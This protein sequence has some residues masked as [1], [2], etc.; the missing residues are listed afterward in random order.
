MAT[1]DILTATKTARERGCTVLASLGAPRAPCALPY[2]TLRRTAK[3]VPDAADRCRTLPTDTRTLLSSPQSADDAAAAVHEASQTSHDTL[4]A[5][6]AAG[7]AVD[8]I[9]HQAEAAA[10]AVGGAMHTAKGGAVEAAQVGYGTWYGLLRYSTVWYA[11][12][13]MREPGDPGSYCCGKGTGWVSQLEQASGIGGTH[14][15]PRYTVTGHKVARVHAVRRAMRFGTDDV[16]HAVRY[17]THS[18]KNRHTG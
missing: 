14:L 16:A 5:K 4:T 2:D 10:Q 11:C 1:K 9:R 17:S 8:A 7:A 6:N 18:K 13:A 15:C 3:A 12:G